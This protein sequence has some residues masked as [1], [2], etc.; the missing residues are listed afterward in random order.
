MALDRATFLTLY[1]EFTRTPTAIVDAEL[2]AASLRTPADVWGDLEDHGHGLLTAHLLC[3][4]PEG[5]EMRLEGAGSIYME[6]RRTLNR[7]VASGF[8]VTGSS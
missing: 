8:R 3:L 6:A 1:P 4:R 7:I 2:A 5:R